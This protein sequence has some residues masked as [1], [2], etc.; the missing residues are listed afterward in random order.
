MAQFSNDILITRNGSIDWLALN[1]EA[2]VRAVSMYGDEVSD[3]DI[4]MWRDKLIAMATMLQ[5]R[6]HQVSA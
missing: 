3:S 2:R 6:A 5:S 1:E 4:T